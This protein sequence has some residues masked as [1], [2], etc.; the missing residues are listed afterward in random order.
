[1]LYPA[2]SVGSCI[3]LNLGDSVFVSSGDSQSLNFP[4]INIKT[5]QS[6]YGLDFDANQTRAYV[7]FGNFM[8]YDSTTLNGI[9]VYDGDCYPGVFVYNASHA[10]YEP[11]TPYGIRQCGIYAIPVES[12]IDLSATYG[13][14]VTRLSASLDRYY[15]QDEPCAVENYTQSKKAYMYNTAYGEAIPAMQYYTVVQSEIDSNRYD[16]RVCYSEKKTNGEHVDN[17]HLALC[18]GPNDPLQGR[19][20]SRV[21][22]TDSPGELGLVLRGSKGLGSPLELR[23]VSLGAH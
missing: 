16:T 19:Q 13:S 7:G 23:R 1:M 9:D 11:N 21:C 20:G 18:S 5:K 8:L 17:C 4:I 15:V 12:D 6:P 22:I 14:L 2:G 10:W 3:L